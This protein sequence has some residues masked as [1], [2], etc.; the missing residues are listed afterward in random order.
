M[1]AP[2]G[3]Q[4]LFLGQVIYVA[5]NFCPAGTLHAD[6]RVMNISEN[7]A[8]FSLLGTAYGGDGQRTN[9]LP[10]LEML[11]SKDTF[12]LACIVVSGR[13]PPR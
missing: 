7:V 9:A 8:L 13:F 4:E 12:G 3:A 6:G 1:F 11:G 2:A 5:S 10:K